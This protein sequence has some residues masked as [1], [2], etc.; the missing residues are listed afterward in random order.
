LSAPASRAQDVDRG[1][2]PSPVQSLSR[3]MRLPDS[4]AFERVFAA[5]HRSADR[6]FTVLGRAR[7]ASPIDPALGA[8]LGLAISKRCANRAVARNRIKR[9]IR[10]SFRL[11]R[12]TLGDIDLVVLCR[13]AAVE[14]DSATLRDSL[15]AHWTR[16]YP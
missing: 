1:A 2:L 7:P 15:R 14:A 6:F 11:T 16:F 10:E 3:S 9:V 5:P 4:R 13:R 12:P 8:R